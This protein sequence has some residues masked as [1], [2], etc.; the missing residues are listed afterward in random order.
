MLKIKGIV[1]CMLKCQVEQHKINAHRHS[2]SFMVDKEILF[3]N[4]E[5]PCHK[6]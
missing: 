3:G 1:T 4:M 5:S 2:G 6:C